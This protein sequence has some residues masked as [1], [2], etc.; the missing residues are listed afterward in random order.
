MFNRTKY[1]VYDSSIPFTARIDSVISWFKLD[2]N[3]RPD[4]SLLYFSEPDHTGHM[5][6]PESMEVYNMIIQSDQILGYLLE[7]LNTLDIKDQINL[8]IFHF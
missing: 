6:G 2:S 4:L 1:K 8:I 5:F 3:E 7:Q